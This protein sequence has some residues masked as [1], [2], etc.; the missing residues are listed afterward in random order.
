[1][2]S[3]F[4]KIIG[5]VLFTFF[6]CM[7]F[8][9]TAQSQVL[10]GS[11]SIPLKGALLDLRENDENSGN[12]NSESGLVLPRVFLSELNSLV[13]ILEGTEPDYENLKPRY[14]G[15]VVYNVNTTSPFEKGIYV[16][17]GISWGKMSTAALTSIQA[18]NGLTVSGGD[19]VELG[20]DLEKN[21]SINLGDYNL[22][23]D[24]NLGKIGIGSSSPQAVM[25]IGNPNSVDPLI[26]QNVKFVTDAQNAIDEPDAVYYD[27]KV[28]EKGVIRKIQTTTT[29][30]NQSF[31]YKL[32]EN[33]LILPGDATSYGTTGL[34]GSELLWTGPGGIDHS[35]IKLPEDGAYVF[36]F[37]LVGNWSS[38]TNI[39]S[40]T[41][42]VSAF[43]GGFNPANLIDI[44]EIVINHTSH[45]TISYSINLTV[46]GKAGDDIHFKISSFQ[47]GDYKFKWTLDAQKTNM[48]FW[49]L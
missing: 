33:T 37:S 23:F 5:Y 19:N 38:G 13:P 48:I 46:S 41:F 12:A 4:N 9:F 45:T 29:S 1:M 32:S 39:E 2:T 34:G 10:I 47:P 30:V 40:N 24:H 15:M 20:G 14:T 27:L 35:F 44:A 21:T 22:L 31:V 3:K 49:R 42:Y 6:L 36:S 43:K 7:C 8:S 16:W 28:S 18:K 26:L 11:E 17:D 25:H